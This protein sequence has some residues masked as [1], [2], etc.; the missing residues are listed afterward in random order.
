MNEIWLSTSSR[1]R[2]V[3]ADS[4]AATI[5]AAVSVDANRTTFTSTPS[6][7]RDTYDGTITELCSR[8][9]VITSSPAPSPSPRSAVFTPS[10]VV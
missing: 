5:S 2:G 9:H 6:R 4:N 1:V 7:S 10:V 8:L 3:I